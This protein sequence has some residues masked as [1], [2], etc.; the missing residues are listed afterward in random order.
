VSK[1][2][3]CITKKINKSIFLRKNCPS[4]DVQ[5]ENWSLK[6]RSSTTVAIRTLN[7]LTNVGLKIQLHTATYVCMQ[8][9][10]SLAAIYE[11]SFVAD[12]ASIHYVTNL[13]ILSRE[14]SQSIKTFTY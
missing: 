7:V 5:F 9:S 2:F 11:G 1:I 4:S 6:T 8:A 12:L 3:V 10:T 13:P 14:V